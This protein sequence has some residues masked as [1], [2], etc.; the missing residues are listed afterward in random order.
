MEAGA[1][2]RDRACHHGGQPGDTEER[3]RV[4]VGLEELPLCDNV[5]HEWSE[6]ALAVRGFG[7]GQGHV[8]ARWSSR[9]LSSG[10]FDPACIP[11]GAV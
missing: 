8:A 10:W 11:T 1:S 3:D 7:C 2:P 5:V 6:L 4:A 9:D